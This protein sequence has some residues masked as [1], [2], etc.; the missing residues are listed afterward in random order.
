M[1]MRGPRASSLP[2][3]SAPCRPR[4][5]L[6]GGTTPALCPAWPCP[7]L[8][9]WGSGW[10]RRSHAAQPRAP[11]VPTP[12]PVWTLVSLRPPCPVHRFR[13]VGFWTRWF[14]HFASSEQSPSA[15]AS[16]LPESAHPSLFCLHL[17]QPIV[18][19]P[20]QNR[21]NLPSTLVPRFCLHP[22]P[23]TPPWPSSPRR[24]PEGARKQLSQVLPSS[25]HS[26][27]GLPP[28]WGKGPNPPLAT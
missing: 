17:A 7:E 11:D 15:L 3:G 8:W 1:S 26:P 19:H 28:S 24:P 4:L 25:A 16:H 9:T 12:A 10:S 6:T 20:D 18:S 14:L 13:A 21:Q 22:P 23:P 5:P 27:P 2:S